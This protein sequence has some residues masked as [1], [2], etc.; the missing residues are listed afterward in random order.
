MAQDKKRAGHFAVCLTCPTPA[1]GSGAA[2]RL[3]NSSQKSESVEMVCRVLKRTSTVYNLSVYELQERLAEPERQEQQ[4]M[5]DLEVVDSL[6]RQL[7]QLG[8]QAQMLNCVL[9][10]QDFAQV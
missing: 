8:R 9:S 3:R 6:Q 5:V 7:R 1:H 2:L 10:E 4:R